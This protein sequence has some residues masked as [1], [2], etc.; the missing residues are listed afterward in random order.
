[1]VFEAIRE[2]IL[3][4][5]ESGVMEATEEVRT[6]ARGFCPVESG[7]LKE[8]IEAE[9]GELSGSVNAGASY[10]AYVELGSRNNAARP[11][12]YP[13]FSLVKG[14]VA[15]KIAEKI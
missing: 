6:L 1:M 11:F 13:A 10:G 15:R 9:Q 7:T 12:L 8:S 14:T 5:A 3:T 4:A 2:A